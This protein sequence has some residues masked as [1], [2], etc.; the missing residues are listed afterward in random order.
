MARTVNF[1]KKL[2]KLAASLEELA[3]A[4]EASASWKWKVSVH[5]NSAL[6]EGSRCAEEAAEGR[7]ESWC[8]RC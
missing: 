5:Q 7:A 6:Q 4:M 3:T 8:A 1:A 2:R